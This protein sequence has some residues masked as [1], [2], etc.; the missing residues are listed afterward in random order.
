[1]RPRNDQPG[2]KTFVWTQILWLT[3]LAFLVLYFFKTY[4]VYGAPD[5]TKIPYTEFRKNVTQGNVADVTIKGSRIRGTFKQPV[6]TRAADGKLTQDFETIMPPIQD[7]ELLNIL[8]N[9]GVVVNAKPDEGSWFGVLMIYLLPW[10]LILGVFLYSS[11][12]L[13][14]R[15]GGGS[16]LFGFGKSKARLYH[17]SSSDVT[18][19]DVAGLA[20]AK[21]EFF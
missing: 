16:N 11:S 4:A 18:F 6:D 8:D 17:K 20:N 12:R 3:M 1:M 15:V 2:R 21:K 9:N 13:S 19:K 7:P 14:N 5:N 10:L